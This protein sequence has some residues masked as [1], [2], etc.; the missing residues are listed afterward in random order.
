MFACSSLCARA[1]QNALPLVGTAHC[2]Y[3]PG[4][5]VGQWGDKLHRFSR[6][7]CYQQG[8]SHVVHM[9]VDVGV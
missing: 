7:Y 1:S 5:A 4:D 3:F 6:M 9:D 8:F 2:I